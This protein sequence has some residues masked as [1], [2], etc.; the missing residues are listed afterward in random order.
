MSSTHRIHLRR[1][2]RFEVTDYRVRWTR[3][4]NRPTGLGPGQQVWLLFEGFA[5]GPWGVILNGQPIATLAGNGAVEQ[6]EI[7]DR[8]ALH[9][10][11][12]LEGA[13]LSRPAL[14]SGEQPPGEVCL[15]IRERLL[16]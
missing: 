9:N 15:E 11:L 8:L 10:E 7:A 14:W 1:P 2:W 5:D 3:P 6:F 4:F 13:H 16:Q 12:A